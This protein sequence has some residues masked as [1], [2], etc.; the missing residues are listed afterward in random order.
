ML[1]G[2][3]TIIHTQSKYGIFLFKVHVITEILYNPLILNKFK[4]ISH[5][6]LAPFICL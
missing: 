4:D 3:A 1:L 2:A 6:S 5:C